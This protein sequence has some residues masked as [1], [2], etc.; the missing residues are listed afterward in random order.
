MRGEHK[1]RSDS[2]MRIQ[3]LKTKRAPRR[4]QL[5]VLVADKNA[6]FRETI[7]RVLARVG[8]CTISGEA[9]TIAEVI[10]RVTGSRID[11]VLLDLDMVTQDRLAELKRL[12]KQ[13]PELKVAVL[14]S[15]DGPEY[16]QAVRMYGGHFSVAKDSLEEQL[17]PVLEGVLAAWEGSAPP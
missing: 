5:R 17:P 3:M 16:R 2:V 8:R 7:R 1:R 4:R 14:L 11:L 15:V 13:L 9:S 10:S 6:H 12:A